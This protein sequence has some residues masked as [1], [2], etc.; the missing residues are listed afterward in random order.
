VQP[1]QQ[2]KTPIS[3]IKFPTKIAQSPYQL[4]NITSATPITKAMEL[5][6]WMYSYVDPAKKVKISPAVK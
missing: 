6:N 4:K 3:V 2:T 5:Y 1:V